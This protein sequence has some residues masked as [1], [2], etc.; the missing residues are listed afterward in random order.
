[1]EL[2]DEFVR[3][4]PGA[5][6]PVPPANVAVP[7]LEK[8]TEGKNDVVPKFTVT[9]DEA[10]MDAVAVFSVVFSA[11]RMTLGA[12]LAP[13]AIAIGLSRKARPCCNV[14]PFSYAITVS[15]TAAAL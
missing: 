9:L 1:M 13:S 2:P 3:T 10:G 5:S 12:P 14:M 7:P 4:R 6:A 8:L 11:A 15:D